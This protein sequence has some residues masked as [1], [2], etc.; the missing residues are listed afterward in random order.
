MNDRPDKSDA[1]LILRARV[2]YVDMSDGNIDIDASPE[3]S[4]TDE[5]AWVAAWVWVPNED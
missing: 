2:L 5:G 4:H 1:D 3:L